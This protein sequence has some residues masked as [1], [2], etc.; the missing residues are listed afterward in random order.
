[1]QQRRN[2]EV[3]YYE[4]EQGNHP[5][6]EWLD[7]DV[8]P[9]AA[10]KPENL[11]ERLEQDPTVIRTKFFGS[12]GDDLYDVKIEHGKIWYRLVFFYYERQAVVCHGF[13]KKDNKVPDH[14]KRLARKRMRDFLRRMET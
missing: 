10:D 4:T 9:K 2:L 13:K 3:I 12:L 1:M 11:L 6:Q 7:E 5:A 14:E 8:E